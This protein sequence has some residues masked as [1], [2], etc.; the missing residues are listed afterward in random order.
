MVLMDFA[1]MFDVDIK[2]AAYEAAFNI[3]T[4]KVSFVAYYLVSIK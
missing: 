2:K 4:H 3:L 1:V